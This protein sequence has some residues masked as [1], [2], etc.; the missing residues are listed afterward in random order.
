MHPDAHNKK[1]STI[2][3][4]VRSIACALDRLRFCTVAT[5]AEFRHWCPNLPPIY[6]VV[7]D[8]DFR[9]DCRSAT[10]LEDQAGEAKRTPWNS[11]YRLASIMHANTWRAFV[12]RND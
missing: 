7:T 11:F 2:E 1:K 12:E 3:R 10:R 9:M 6:D 4:K 8:L 5:K